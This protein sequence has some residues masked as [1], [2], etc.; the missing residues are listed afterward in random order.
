MS[1]TQPLLDTIEPDEVNE[2][3]P[4]SANTRA[5]PAPVVLT[6]GTRSTSQMAASSGDAEAGVPHSFDGTAKRTDLT[7]QVSRA[8]SDKWVHSASMLDVD[9]ETSIQSAHPIA[10]FFLY[11]FRTAAI[12]VYLLCGFFTNNYVLSVRV[13]NNHCT[14]MAD[15][16]RYRR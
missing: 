15:H 7:C 10:L 11:F 5:P 14:V 1:T 3:P 12:V 6:P 16:R 9:S 4:P 8:Y 13:R 2:A